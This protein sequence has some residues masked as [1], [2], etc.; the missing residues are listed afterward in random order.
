MD[1]KVGSPPIVNLTSPRRSLSSTASP[2][3]RNAIHCASV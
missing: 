1:T 3:A 2:A